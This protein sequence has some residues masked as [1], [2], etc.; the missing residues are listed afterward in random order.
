MDVALDYLKPKTATGAMID[1]KADAAAICMVHSPD[2][3]VVRQTSAII[4]LLAAGKEPYWI[5]WSEDLIEKGMA[6]GWG[7]FFNPI[8]VPAGVFP[9]HM[10][11]P[12]RTTDMLVGWGASTD[13]PE[14]LAYEFTKWYI[15][16]SGKLSEYT[17]MADTIA[18]PEWLVYMVLKTTGSTAERVFHPGAL[19]AY[20]EAGIPVE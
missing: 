17:A 20:R 18:Q 13:F 7:P 10:P 2:F 9:G 1:G 15:Q 19:R 4:D 11:T 14:E 16:N 6:E 12:L 3:S 8:E 5:S